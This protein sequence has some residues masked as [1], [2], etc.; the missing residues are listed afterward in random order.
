MKL[1]SAAHKIFHTMRL[2]RSAHTSRPWRI[3][4]FTGDFELEDV[5]ELPTPGGPD[6]L[7]EW[8]SEIANKTVHSLMHIGWVPDD[9]AT[10]V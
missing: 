5:W 4:E 1:P 8:V 3:H 6:D 10:P 9:S 7:D 2:P